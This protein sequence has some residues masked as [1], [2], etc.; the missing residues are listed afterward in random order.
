MLMEAQPHNILGLRDKVKEQIGIHIF[1]V[2][3]RYG[4]Q[5]R[6]TSQNGHLFPFK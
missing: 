2:A 5:R 3:T 4:C 1:T 6:H